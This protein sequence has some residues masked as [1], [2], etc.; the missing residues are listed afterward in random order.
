MAAARMDKT[1]AFYQRLVTRGPEP[2]RAA[3]HRRR[4]PRAHGVKRHASDRRMRDEGI[5]MNAAVD[6]LKERHGYARVALAGQSGG[7]RIV[8]QLLVLGRRDIVCAAMGVRRLRCAAH[9]ARRPDRTNIFGDPGRKF[10]VPLHHA[11]GHRVLARSSRLR[12]GDPPRRTHALLRTARVGRED[13]GA[14]PPRRA[15]RG[16]GVGP[17]ASWPQR[18]RAPVAAMCATGRTDQE[19]AAQVAAD[20]CRADEGAEPARRRSDMNRVAHGRGRSSFLA[21]CEQPS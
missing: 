4:P 2:V 3:V 12:I 9:Q 20:R 17:R 21:W 7:A 16:R 13:A 11:D 18:R 19:I 5:T 8:A 10:L 6:A 1:V 15:A 14:R